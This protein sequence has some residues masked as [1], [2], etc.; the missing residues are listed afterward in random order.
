[1]GFLPT[2]APW[3]SPVVDSIPTPP[4]A[5]RDEH[6]RYVRMLQLHL[7]M[8]DDGEP[9]LSTIALLCALADRRRP[10]DADSPDLSALELRVSLTS[11]FPVPWTPTALAAALTAQSLFA[12]RRQGEGWVWEGDPDF[13]AQPQG[14]GWLIT[15]RERGDTETAELADDRDLVVLWMQQFRDKFGFPMAHTYD[16]SDVAALVPAVAAVRRADAI[17]AALPYR[18]SWRAE[19]E[20]AISAFRELGDRDG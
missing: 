19:R 16:G 1:M 2:T 9:A 10:A 18:A 13:E 14:P 3:G 17:D 6:V 7:A 15:R 20:A 8:L 4:F 11:W 12:P 5:S